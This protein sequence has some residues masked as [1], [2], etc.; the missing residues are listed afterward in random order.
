[1]LMFY[2]YINDE[3]GKNLRLSFGMDRIVN[4]LLLLVSL[5]LPLF[6]AHI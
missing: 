1:M 4:F 3:A 2:V 5:V 6:F